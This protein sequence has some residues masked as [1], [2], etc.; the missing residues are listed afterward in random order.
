MIK[1]AKLSKRKR[2]T[3]DKGKEDRMEWALVS[4]SNPKKILKWFGPSKPSKKAVLKEEGRV[5]YFSGSAADGLFFADNFD[6]GERVKRLRRKSGRLTQT[7]QPKR[8][9]EKIK[10][11]LNN[12]TNEHRRS[13]MLKELTAIAN[14]LDTRGLTKEADVLDGIL[15]TVK[16]AS[17]KLVQEVDGVKIYK[18][19]DWGGYIVSPPNATDEEMYHTDDLDDAIGTAKHMSKTSEDPLLSYEQVYEAAE[20]YFNDINTSHRLRRQPVLGSLTSVE[21]DMGGSWGFHP[22]GLE[23]GP[24]EDS[25]YKIKLHVANGSKVSLQLWEI[26][27]DDVL[28]F[29]AEHKSVEDPVAW[30]NGLRIPGSESRIYVLGTGIYPNAISLSRRVLRKDA[31]RDAVLGG[32]GIPLDEWPGP[33]AGF[34]VLSHSSGSLNASDFKSLV[35]TGMRIASSGGGSLGVTFIPESSDDIKESLRRRVSPDNKAYNLGSTVI[36]AAIDPSL[37]VDN[38][39]SDEVL[40]SGSEF[41]MGGAKPIKNVRVLESWGPEHEWS[42]NAW[43]LPGRFL[44]AAYDGASDLIY[45]NE[46]WSGSGGTDLGERMAS[47]LTEYNANRPKVEEDSSDVISQVNEDPDIW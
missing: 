26:T 1:D 7:K 18:D 46:E 21:S 11:S 6:Y 3:R 42:G 30:T 16:V 40:S 25:E 9:S 38:G 45:I 15:P 28:M 2:T 32:A 10:F 44:L 12:Q 33:P 36:I 24:M 8:A 22:N 14:E 39:V 37:L 35:G 29:K 31:G 17:R 5:N 20:E 27:P 47:N 41:A 4:K 19:S 34:H 23:I 13:G 43:K